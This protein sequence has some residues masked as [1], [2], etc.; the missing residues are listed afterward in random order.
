LGCDD[1]P[2][3]DVPV[4]LGAVLEVVEEATVDDVVSDVVVVAA[5]AVVVAGRVVVVGV[6][7]VVAVEPVAAPEPV[8]VV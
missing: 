4:R 2:V 8:V 5:V 1:E 6:G 7:A 3:A